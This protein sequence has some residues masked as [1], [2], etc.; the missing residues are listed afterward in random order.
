MNK[1]EFIKIYGFFGILIVLVAGLVGICWITVRMISEI[2]NIIF[3]EH[4][5]SNIDLLIG[6]CIACTIIVVGIP[7]IRLY[8]N[9]F[10]VVMEDIIKK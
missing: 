3:V 2:Y 6:C 5:V 4:S 10:I 8:S 1:L 7:F 9:M